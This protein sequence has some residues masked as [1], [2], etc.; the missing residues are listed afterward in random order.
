MSAS[1]AYLYAKLL[2]IF[3]TLIIRCKD[4][5][6]HRTDAISFREGAIFVAFFDL[7]G[8]LNKTAIARQYF[9]MSQKWKLSSGIGGFSPQ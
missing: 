7:D 8:L 3:G 1:S 6:S 9:G 4:K 2:I 5:I